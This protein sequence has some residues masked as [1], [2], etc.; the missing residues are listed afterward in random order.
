MHNERADIY[1]ILFKFQKSLSK[2]SCSESESTKL[3][4]SESSTLKETFLALLGNDILGK[5][6]III[7]K[8]SDRCMY[9]LIL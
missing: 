2:N 6:G 9:G 8:I 7:V 1:I 5:T 4:P 3:G